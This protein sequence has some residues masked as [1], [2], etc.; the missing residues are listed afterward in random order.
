MVT[1]LD[2]TRTN[3]NIDRMRG[4]E[5]V[6]PPAHVQHTKDDMQHMWDFGGSQVCC[7]TS[8]SPQSYAQRQALGAAVTRADQV[9]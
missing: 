7:C 6:Q 5:L 8:L 3:K 9:L 2:G 4:P 1:Q